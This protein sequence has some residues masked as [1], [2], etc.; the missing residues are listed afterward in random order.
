M[1]YHCLKAS[2]KHS[3]MLYT[4]DS[5]YPDTARLQEIL[6]AANLTQHVEGVTHIHGHCLDLVISREDDNLVS[7]TEIS[8]LVS[9]HFAVHTQLSLKA[10]P[11]E[12]K[13]ITYRKYKSIDSNSFRTDLISSE[14]VQ[15]PQTDLD[16][17]LH[18]YNTCLKYLLDKHAPLRK[19]RLHL[20]KMYPGIPLKFQQKNMS[21]ENVKLGGVKVVLL[22][23]GR[24][25]YDPETE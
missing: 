21:V 5:Q 1:T 6:D 4:S 25:T 12:R 16:N 18:Q 8:S 9:D 22:C 10:P 23:T 17:L 2:I 24:S 14:L 15:S 20:M 11:L 13:I 3:V 19:S 7:K